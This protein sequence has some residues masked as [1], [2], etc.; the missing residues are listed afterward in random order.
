MVTVAFISYFRILLTNSG[1]ILEL[2]PFTK[3]L[4]SDMSDSSYLIEDLIVMDCNDEHVEFLILTKYTKE[5]DR[6]IKIIDYPG[7]NPIF[8]K[9]FF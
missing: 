4:I 7:N 9:I 1:H 6:C 2:C 8:S 3:I 5:N